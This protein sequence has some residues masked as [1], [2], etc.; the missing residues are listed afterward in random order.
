[1]DNY[2]NWRGYWCGECTGYGNDY[3]TDENGELKCRCPDCMN[4]ED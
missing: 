1:M 3:Y 4:D 2:N